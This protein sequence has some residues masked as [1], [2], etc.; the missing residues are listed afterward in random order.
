MR[1]LSILTRT[2]ISII[3]IVFTQ[4]CVNLNEKVYDTITSEDFYKIADKDQ[5]IVASAYAEVRKI[6]QY[7]PVWDSE[8]LTTDEQVTPTRGT[9]WDEGGVWRQLHEHTW[10]Y[11]H[12]HIKTIWEYGFG[13]VN[14]ANE[15]TYRLNQTGSQKYKDLFINELPI[16]RAFGYYYL[17]NAFGNVPI[18][19]QYDVPVGY[20]PKNETNFEA[21][22]KTAFNFAVNDITSTI[23]KLSERKGGEYYGRFNKWAAYA[24][25]AKYYLNAETWT[26]TP[27]WDECI[28]ACDAI[29]TKGGYRLEPDYFANFVSKN[30]GSK[31]NIFVIPFDNTL[32]PGGLIFWLYYLHYSDQA[33]Y[34]TA[35]QP[36]NGPCAI[37]SFI[38]SFN[39]DDKRLKG[40]L[41]G[42]RIAPNGDTLRCT[43]DSKDKPLNYTVD[44]VNIYKKDNIKY[45]HTN[46]REYFGARFAKYEIEPGLS[47]SSM[48]NDLAI[49]RLADIMLM[50]AE[51]LMRKHGGATQEAVDLVNRVRTRAFDNDPSPYTVATLTLETLLKERGWE[52]YNECMRRTDLI[53]FKKFVRGPWEFANRSAES[54]TRNV[55]PIPQSAISSNTNLTQNPGY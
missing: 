16:V 22:R 55:F 31:E 3:A 33:Y 19:D 23:A 8:S 43:E 10:N 1:K 52:L 41:T 35:S 49:Y 2:A 48:G 50:K 45:D 14:K 51:A 54:D 32:T 44:F 21:G 24:L 11:E 27:K 42:L 9:N 13:C 34:N 29:I 20:L 37:P 36:W 15:V 25:L 47:G 38:K 46:S 5:Y 30:E 28:E 39:K 4:A 40:W 12:L 7:I 26:G 6:T 18:V 17:I 53:R